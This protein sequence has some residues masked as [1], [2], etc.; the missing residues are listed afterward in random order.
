[1]GIIDRTNDL[2]G[3]HGEKS[4][5]DKVISWQTPNCRGCPERKEEKH[6]SPEKYLVL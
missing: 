6:Y 2:H 3:I 4:D 5:N 1:M